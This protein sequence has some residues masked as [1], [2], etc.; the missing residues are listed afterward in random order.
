MPGCKTPSLSNKDIGAKLAEIQRVLAGDAPLRLVV[1]AFGTKLGALEFPTDPDTQFGVLLSSPGR[2][3]DQVDLTV[4][5]VSIVY[6]RGGQQEVK[7]AYFDDVVVTVT[8]ANLENFKAASTVIEIFRP[9]QVPPGKPDE[10]TEAIRAMQEAT[11]E[12]LE[13]LHEEGVRRAADHLQELEV[14]YRTREEE[15]TRLTELRKAE[16]DTAFAAEKSKLDH[17]AEAL[18]A[19]SRDLDDRDN[20]HAR[21]ETRN[22]MLGDVKARISAFG[23]SQ[24]TEKK[25]RPVAVGMMVLI[26]AL[27]LAAVGSWGELWGYESVRANAIE[28]LKLT[29]RPSDPSVATSAAQSVDALLGDK[30]QTVW[31]LWFRV[32]TLTLGF[33]GAVLYY[34]RWQNKWAEQHAQSE[35]AL[36]QFELDVNRANWIIESCLEWRKGTDSPIPTVLLESI[37]RGLF[38]PAD[39]QQEPPLNPADELAKALLST[40]SKL[41]L[42][43]GD[44]ELEFDKPSKIAKG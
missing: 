14:R 1:R 10:S 17:E 26:T 34:I 25:R 21:R 35:F 22:R 2:S 6:Y 19:R 13:R 9:L 12:R 37:T 44:S 43:A 31:W 5:A 11:L 16:L 24:A 40:S 42:K 28:A 4:G 36:Q 18:A 39:T 41:K 32:S 29:A 30:G 7:S 27:L 38:V 23:V 33:V 8:D 3:I 20:T 15:L